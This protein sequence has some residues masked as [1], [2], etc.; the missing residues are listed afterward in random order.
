MKIVICLKTLLSSR[1]ARCVKDLN[2]TS[3]LLKLHSAFMRGC[4]LHLRLA[5]LP[6]V[7]KCLH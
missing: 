4:D 7:F 5:V 2:I 1:T 6:Q 3:Y